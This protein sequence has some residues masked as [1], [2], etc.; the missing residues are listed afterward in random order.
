MGSWIQPGESRT[1]S[2][3]LPWTLY[4]EDPRFG[5]GKYL[6]GEYLVGLIY[7]FGRDSRLFDG[8][9][10]LYLHALDRGLA[11]TFRGAFVPDNPVPWEGLLKSNLLRIQVLERK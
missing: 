6:L 11:R 1:W 9:R 7:E 8:N 2:Q 4:P 3:E 5:D 10:A